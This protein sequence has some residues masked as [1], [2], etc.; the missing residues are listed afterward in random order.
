M[1]DFETGEWLAYTIDVQASALYDIELRVSS[2]FS[3]SALRVEID[4]RDATGTITVPNT[5]SSSEFQWVGR[6]GVPISAGRHVL[7][8]FAVEQ[9]FGLNSIRLTRSA[10]QEPPP[11][12]VGAQFFCTFPTSPTDC[13]FTEEAKVPGRATIVGNGRDGATAV[14]LHTEP[15]DDNVAGS[16]SAER[17]ALRLSQSETD[18]FAGR[19]QWWAHS[20]LF[21][22]DYRAPD[23]GGWGVAFDFHDSSNQCLPGEVC[24]ANFHVLST[25]ADTQALDGRLAFLGYGGL[26]TA[27]VAYWAGIG[28]VAKNEWRRLA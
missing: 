18:G 4:G 25:P 22:S 26:T 8:V 23:P 21:P 9:F 1:S 7:K 27:P 3:N 2:T 10:Q 28:N 14:R 20:I 17:N 19:E 12:P 16:N 13:G 6:T 11:P 5:G 24:Q 15:G